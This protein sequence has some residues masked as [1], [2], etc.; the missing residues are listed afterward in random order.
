MKKSYLVNRSV[1]R[2]R[3]GHKAPTF[4]GLI[5]QE[6]IKTSSLKISTKIYIQ[7]IKTQI[8][9]TTKTTKKKGGE[10]HEKEESIWIEIH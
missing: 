10:D 5:G 2:L 9:Q 3:D 8:T 4:F 6:Q 7:H 1:E